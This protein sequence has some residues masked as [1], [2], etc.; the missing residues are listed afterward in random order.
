M[1]KTKNAPRR[2][3]A[4]ATLIELNQDLDRIES[5]HRAGTLVKTGNWTPGMILEHV[6]IGFEFSLD[7]FPIKVAAPARAIFSLMM[8]KKLLSGGAFPAGISP[9]PKFL[10]KGDPA[11]AEPNERVTFDEGLKRLKEV[12]LRLEQGA[13]MIKPSPV[14]GELTHDE[15]VR[16]QLS[17]AALHLGFLDP[18]S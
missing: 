5:A 15:S 2:S 9:L 16:L 7:G 4:Y 6:A 11:A 12:L 13:K 17:H 18:N 8:K 14:F 3:C 10:V 1:V